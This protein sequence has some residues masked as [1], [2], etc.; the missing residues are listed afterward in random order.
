MKVDANP[1]CPECGSD[2]TVVKVRQ[3]LLYC[4]DCEFEQHLDLLED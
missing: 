1:D 4:E 2:A 3:S